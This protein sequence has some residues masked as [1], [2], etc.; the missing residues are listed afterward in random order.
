VT[1]NCWNWPSNARNPCRRRH[2]PA[3]DDPARVIW[4]PPGPSCHGLCAHRPRPNTPLRASTPAGGLFTTVR[5]RVSGCQFHFLDR[6]DCFQPFTRAPVRPTAAN[7]G[8]CS[9][10]GGVEAGGV[11]GDRH[12]AIW[13][14]LP[15]SYCL[16]GG[17]RWGGC[18]RLTTASGRKRCTRLPHGSRRCPSPPTPWPHC[19]GR[20]PG[21]SACIGGVAFDELKSWPARI[22]TW[23]RWRALHPSNPKL[24]LAD[25]V[26]ATDGRPRAPSRV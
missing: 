2:L 12:Y 11:G 16:P 9:Q 1:S 14:T 3:P 5:A 25:A 23:A 21:M 19:N 24:V 17:R 4:R 7:P 26:T 6:P 10:P 18:A 15:N 8:D 20:W 13:A 22:S